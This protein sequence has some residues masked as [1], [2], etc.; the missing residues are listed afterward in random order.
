VLSGA[1]L[2]GGV[3]TNTASVVLVYFSLLALFFA[4]CYPISR[5]TQRL[6]RRYAF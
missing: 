1:R 2:E 5:L 6:E 4:Y 3:F